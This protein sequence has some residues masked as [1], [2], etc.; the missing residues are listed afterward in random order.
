MSL[1]NPVP[2]K[3]THARLVQQFKFNIGTEGRETQAEAINVSSS[4]L[5][6]RVDQEI[7]VMTQVEI[8]LVLTSRTQSS[9]SK[10]IS[11]KGV[12]VRCEPDGAKFKAAIFFTDIS[13]SH[14]RQV[15][16]WVRST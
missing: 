13:D 6:C 2:E 9:N 14:R 7:A 10:Q 12:V 15:D 8:G 16:A 3:R 1:D 5:L 11:I 4:G